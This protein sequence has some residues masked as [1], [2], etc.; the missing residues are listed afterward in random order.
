MFIYKIKNILNHKFYIGKTKKNPDKRFKEHFYLSKRSK[1]H[2]HKAIKKYG[3]DNFQVEILE[4]VDSNEL[5]NEKEKYWIEKL[6]PDYNKTSGG[7]GVVG[8]SYTE[9]HKKN[10]SLSK[11]GKK[12]SN[13]HNLNISL[14]KKG[15]KQST[16]HIK[17]RILARKVKTHSEI[18]KQ[19]ISESHKNK[20]KPKN[21]CR[22][23]DKKL[24]NVSNFVFWSKLQKN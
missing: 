13:S 3:V 8:Y 2:F 4:V 16:E 9:E 22:L 24:M 11:K 21:V 10:M 18:S 12:N 14:S 23:Y 7:D 5:L 6:K 17:N 15:K 20:P 19:K 1:T